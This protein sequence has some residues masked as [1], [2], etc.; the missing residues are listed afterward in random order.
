MYAAS[1][2]G[3]CAIWA[4]TFRGR[5]V[6]EDR[7]IFCKRGRDASGAPSTVWLGNRLM[8]I[9]SFVVY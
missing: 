8:G 5:P 1:T 6:G 7:A 2:A 4:W 9:R 3:E